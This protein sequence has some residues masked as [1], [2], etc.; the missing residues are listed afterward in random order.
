MRNRKK[1]NKYMLI[2]VVILAVSI[3]YAAV[4]TTLKF[5]G[6][7]TVMKHSWDVH[8]SNPVVVEGS[9]NSNNVPAI[10]EDQGDPSNTKLTWTANLKIP[11]DYY[12]FT[13]DT[14]NSGTVDVMISNINLSVSPALPDY[15]TFDAAYEDGQPIEIN[16]KLAKSTKNGNTIIPTTEKLR[17]RVYYDP[18]LATLET[19]NSIP[20][21]GI[22]YTFTYNITYSKATSD[23]V[24]RED[25]K[26]YYAFYS[27]GC[28]VDDI[29]DDYEF[30]QQYQY[31]S[32]F[33]TLP[34]EFGTSN[35]EATNRYNG[36]VTTNYKKLYLEYK[37][38]RDKYDENS[39]FNSKEEARYS[40]RDEDDIEYYETKSYAPKI[41]YAYKIDNSREVLKNYICVSY[42]NKLVCEDRAAYPI[43]KMSDFIPV[44][45]EYN[46]NT[47]K[48]C[49]V[50]PNYS[51]EFDCISSDGKMKVAAYA[52]TVDVIDY[53]NH[54]LYYYDGGGINGPKPYYDED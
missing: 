12:E 41:F 54:V 21:E 25:A 20:Q 7:A 2:L 4:S 39:Y 3:G 36:G 46:S 33:D 42:N 1:K 37:L 40:G 24:P 34:L 17:V 30:V 19:L 14:A 29:F 32:Y 10:G 16:H 48:G 44:F 49:R 23:A 5:S 26:L 8:W 27:A 38:Y 31:P 28:N 45:G 11:G 50:N 18:E 52:D 35:A 43:F 53:E 47:G 51:N 22:S 6:T 13:V 9:V 15:I